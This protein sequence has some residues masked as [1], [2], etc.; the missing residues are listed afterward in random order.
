[1]KPEFRIGQGW[2]VHRFGAERALL[3]GGVEVPCERGGLEGH[4]DADVLTHALASALLG[5]V[6]LGDLGKHFPDTD[7]RWRN[8]SSLDLLRQVLR[9]VRDAGYRLVNCDCTVIAQEPRLAPHMTAMRQSLAE[10]LAVEPERIS[11]KATTAEGL[12]A[13]GRVEGIAAQAVV[14]VTRS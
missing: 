7:P 14:L 6:A 4:S 10:T 11:I 3:L 2:D 1:M 9:L 5:S 8:A 13:L 12:G